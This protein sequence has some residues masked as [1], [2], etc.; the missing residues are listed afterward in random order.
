MFYFKDYVMT[1]A[2]YAYKF[3]TKRFST[4]F[5]VLTVGAIATDLVVDKGGDYLFSQYNKGKLWKD[6]KDKYV[7]DLAFTG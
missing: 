6:I 7:D 1:L 4:L 5:V 3:I 2:T